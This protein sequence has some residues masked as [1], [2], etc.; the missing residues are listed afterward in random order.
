M[1]IS[2]LFDIAI[3][4]LEAQENKAFNPKYGVGA[5]RYDGTFCLFGGMIEE[6]YYD[7]K[8]DAHQD[9]AGAFVDRKPVYDTSVLAAIQASTG[10]N[11]LDSLTAEDIE[12]IHGIHDVKWQPGHSF[13]ALLPAEVSAKVWS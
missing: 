6:N 1:S 11:L 9:D 7:T 4:R 12:I 8:M 5:Y 3:S 2:D 10:I 13:K